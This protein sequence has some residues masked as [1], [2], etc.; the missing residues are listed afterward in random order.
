MNF[1]EQ[2]NAVT[3]EEI[4]VKDLDN[5][6]ELYKLARDDYDDK[7]RIASEANRIVEDYEKKL[8]EYLLIAGKSKYFVENL[9]TISTVE[10]LYIATPK[11]NSD[12]E[13]FF[14]W[15]ESEYGKDGLLKYQT[16]NSQSLN[17][18]FKLYK[19]E[20][21]EVTSLPGLG[22]ATTNIELRFLKKK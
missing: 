19:E 11:E 21:P 8:L 5:L 6:V 12:K 20:H 2:F 16:V 4:N 22:E 3:S 15:V 17:S 18:L 7:K 9:G 13:L 1:A 14:Q 10:K